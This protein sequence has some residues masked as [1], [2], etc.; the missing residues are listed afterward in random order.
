ME[1][2]IPDSTLLTGVPKPE[3]DFLRE[4]IDC[5]SSKPSGIVSIDDIIVMSNSIHDFHQ[6][7][8]EHMVPKSIEQIEILTRGQCSNESWYSFRKGVITA[9]KAH[10]VKTKMEMFS[11]GGSCGNFW[12]LFQKISGLMFVSP[13]IPALKY[14]RSM[15]VNA[16]N[17][18]CDLFSE[19]HK[20]VKVEEC[21]LFLDKTLPVIGASP[22]RIIS[23][24]CCHKACLEVKCPYSISYTSPH[25]PKVDLPYFK[26][27]DGK[28]SLHRSHQYFTQC[29]MQ[30]GVT[31]LEFCYFFVWTQH[32]FVMEKI[33]FDLE[34]WNNLKKKLSD[35]Y[36]HYLTHTFSST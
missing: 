19:N 36:V 32:G 33:Q 9:S 6:N 11:K 2:V 25:D 4:V 7:V 10:K 29:Q 12:Q 24:P 30:M 15:E 13:N 8:T 34:F 5:S 26:R 35:F 1:K 17:V 14:G 16:V 23:C 3:I 28:L 31:G 21:G 18:F 22:D 27:V 20:N